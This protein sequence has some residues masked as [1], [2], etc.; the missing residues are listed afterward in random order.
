MTLPALH[1][2]IVKRNEQHVRMSAQLYQYLLLLGPF[3]NVTLGPDPKLT[4][5][6]LKKMCR[7]WWSH[8][9]QANVSFFCQ[10]IQSLQSANEKIL[11]NWGS[12]QVV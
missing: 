7:G 2:K 12:V 3:R 8:H 10:P 6:T 1:D 4:A 5:L 9:D 11:M